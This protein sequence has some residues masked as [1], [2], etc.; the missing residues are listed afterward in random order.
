MENFKKKDVAIIGGGDKALEEAIFL[1]KLC[2]RI[3]IIIRKSKMRASQIM[4]KKIYNIKLLFNFE[5]KKIIKY[6]KKNNISLNEIINFK[7]IEIIH[8]INPI[9]IIHSINPIQIIHSIN[10]IQIIHSINPI[11]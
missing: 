3:Y 8:S 11:H 9:Q 4:Q 10:P 7:K 6:S 5:I 1:S 2:N